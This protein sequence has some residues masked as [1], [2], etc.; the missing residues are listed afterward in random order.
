MKSTGEQLPTGDY[1]PKHVFS[2]RSYYDVTDELEFDLGLYG[3]EGMGVDFQEAEY[4]RL[5]ARLGWNFVEGVEAYVGVQGATEPLRSEYDDL[6]Q[7]RR[8]AY[9]GVRATY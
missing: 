4:I 6:D 1:S 8:T 2:V 5:D 9:L 7:L 3:V